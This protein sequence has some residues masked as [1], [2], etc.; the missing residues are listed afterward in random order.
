MNI[1]Q[2][3]VLRDALSA[4]IEQAEQAGSA[5]VALSGTLDAQLTTA[6][7][8]LQADIDAARNG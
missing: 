6:I 3:R 5:E 2:A 4:A 1:E 8:G 7:D